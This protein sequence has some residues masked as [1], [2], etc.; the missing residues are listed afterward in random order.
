MCERTEVYRSLLGEPV[1]DPGDSEGDD[2]PDEPDQDLLA[3]CVNA[4]PGEGESPDGFQEDGEG[5]DGGERPGERFDGEQDSGEAEQQKDDRAAHVGCGLEVGGEAGNG[6][7]DRQRG[8]RRQ[9]DEGDEPQQVGG[10]RQVGAHQL[11][12]GEHHA[13]CQDAQADEAEHLSS[14]EPVRG[15]RG[16]GQSS[17]DAV[18]FVA[19]GDRHH[20]VLELVDDEEDG[21]TGEDVV[22]EAEGLVAETK[23][24]T[25]H[26]PQDEDLE[27]GGQHGEDHAPRAKQH[28]PTGLE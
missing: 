12:Q 1:R 14:D 17:Q 6:E 26:Q 23:A 10:D 25:A 27:R 18:G 19:G 15:D 22:D 2:Q 24:E 5:D 9:R 8:E 21:V 11:A 20:D 7:G 16:D 3:V 4:L 13:G 28:L